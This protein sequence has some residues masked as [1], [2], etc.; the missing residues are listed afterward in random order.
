MSNISRVGVDAGNNYPSKSVAKNRVA[1]D[2][3]D[4][5]TP[6]KVS[7]SD[8]VSIKHNQNADVLQKMV[9][10]LLQSQAAINYNAQGFLEKG[11]NNNFLSEQQII[12]IKS[13]VESGTPIDP[14]QKAEAVSAIA[15]GG[16][17]SAEAVSDRL[18]DFAVTLSGGDESKFELLKGAIE[19]GFTEAERVWGGKLPQISYDTK[20]L[21]MKKLQERF[22][23][24]TQNESLP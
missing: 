10:T 2:K 7:R 23:K 9:R 20:D 21:T 6:Q 18:A 14:A 15:D 5:H 16:L 8:I 11:A 19:E 22:N 13:L 17:W 4:E 24:K 3:L 12:K 1:Q